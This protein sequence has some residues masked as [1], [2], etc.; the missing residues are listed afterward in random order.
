MSLSQI[1]FFILPEE[2]PSFEEA[3]LKRGALFIIL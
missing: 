2:L 3:F 1:N